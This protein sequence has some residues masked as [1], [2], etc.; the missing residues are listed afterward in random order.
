MLYSYQHF[1]YSTVSSVAEFHVRSC[2]SSGCGVPLVETTALPVYNGA[3][4][5]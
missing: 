5:T 1:V 4:V 3:V 2:V